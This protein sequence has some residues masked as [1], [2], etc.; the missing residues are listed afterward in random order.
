MSVYIVTGKLGQGK[1]LVAVSKI[2]EYF[3]AG[4]KIATNLNLHFENL[5]DKYADN[6]Q[7]IRLPGQPSVE[8][9]NAIGRGDS[10]SDY[11]EDDFGLIVLDE[12]GTWFNSRGWNDPGRRDLLDWFLHARKLGWD[13]IFIVQSIEILDKQARETLGEHTVF[14]RRT[15]RIT[16][17]ILSPF[18][19]LVTGKR[20]TFPRC[21]VGIVKYGTSTTS[22]TVDKWWYRGSDLFRLYDTRQVFIRDDTALHTVLPPW[23]LAGRYLPPRRKSKNTDYLLFPVRVAAY[24]VLRST[25]SVSGRS[26]DSLAAEWSRL[27]YRDYRATTVL[28][29]LFAGVN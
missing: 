29:N 12:C 1:S 17:P 24:L 26:P 14:C 16:V 8:D 18:Y 4:K 3:R 28:L 2:F 25:A 19:K 9:M 27:R 15:D 20:L 5:A 6:R 22:L 21:H 13:I 7:V 10:T 23:Y 11:N